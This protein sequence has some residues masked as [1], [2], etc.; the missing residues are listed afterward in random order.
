MEERTRVVVVTGGRGALGGVVMERFARQGATVVGID[1]TGSGEGLT[2]DGERA[3]TWWRRADLTR[4]SEVRA[5]FESIEERFGGVDV[6]VHCAGG[7]RFT[8]MD[9]ASD[10]DIDFL[11]DVNL[12]SSLYV[13]RQSLQIMKRGG[14]GR[15]VLMSSRSTLKP[16]AGEGAYTATKAGLNAL[17]MAVA[18][19]VKELDIR[20]NSIQ[21]VIIDTAANREAMPEAPHEKWVKPS[22][23]AEIIFT[24]TTAV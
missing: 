10:A 4:A 15:I 7:F 12:R 20:V 5:A 21:P 9:E 16:G 11:V 19:E 24:L 13:M 2:E 6:V 22:E 8:H 23:L 18:E 14:Y 17:T 3:H 1:I